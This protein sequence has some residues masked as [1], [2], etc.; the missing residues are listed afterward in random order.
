L[1]RA[2]TPVFWSKAEPVLWECRAA[3]RASD[4]FA[5]LLRGSELFEH[6]ADRLTLLT[7]YP[8]RPLEIGF[9]YNEDHLRDCLLG[10][11]NEFDATTGG[12]QCFR[13]GGVK[14]AGSQQRILIPPEA[15]L[16]GM[17]WFRR[18]MTLDGRIDQFAAYFIALES[19]ACH[20][21]TDGARGQRRC[22]SCGEELRCRACDA[23][24]GRETPANAGIRYL[25]SKR[26]DIPA[27]AR[28]TL[29][30]I[31]ARVLHGNADAQTLVLASA[32]LP[33]IQRLALDGI[34]T[35]LGI[36]P[37][38]LNVLAP[39]PVETIAPMLEA[40]FSEEGNPAV[41]WGGLLS[42]KFERWKVSLPPPQQQ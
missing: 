12:Q 9:I 40:Q 21:Q 42:D 37:T 2:T 3:V 20:I 26:P 17:R 35:V 34:A 10:M 23:D 13:T 22:S 19:V 39:S 6:V 16:E 31:R 18:A 5:A 36:D 25:L 15:A 27:G 28:K 41:V 8:V 33:I 30:R 11:R 1:Q 24:G 38:A 29:A 7:G 32:N 14:N 4:W